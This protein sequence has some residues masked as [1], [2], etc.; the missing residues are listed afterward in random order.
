MLT[1]YYVMVGP[2]KLYVCIDL[3]A[4]GNNPHAG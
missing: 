2:T 3:R 1:T 4:V